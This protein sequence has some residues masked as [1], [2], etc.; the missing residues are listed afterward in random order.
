MTGELIKI[1][2]FVGK[3]ISYEKVDDDADI[4]ND[5]DVM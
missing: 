1:F 2:K 3:M 5:C 4:S